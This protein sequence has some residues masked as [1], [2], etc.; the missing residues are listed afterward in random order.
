MHSRQALPALT[1]G[2][3]GVVFGDIGTSPLYAMKE[4]FNGHHP[5][6][7]TPENIFGILSMVFWSIMVMVSIKY[8]AIIMRADNRGEG[9]SLALLA[10]I[11]DR[12]KSSGMTWIITLLG[13]FAAALFYGDSM[14]TPAISVLSAVEGLEIV[15]PTLKPYVIP[16]TLGILTG[17]FLIQK[18]GTG[19]VGML[20]GPVMMLW[21]AMLGIL[22]VMEVAHNP[23]VLVALNPIHAIDFIHTHTGLAFLALGSV[24][25]AVTGGEALYTD[26]GHF[27]PFP[28]RLAWFGFV[29][30]TLVL[31]YFG[32]GALLLSEPQ[33][34]TSPFFH[35]APD[36][37]LIPLVAMATV[38]T[39][40]ASQAVI[41]GAFSVAR[42]AI[43]M[44]FLPRMLIVHTSDQA[45]GQIYVPF[46]NWTLYL[47]VVALVIGFENSSNLA[48]AYG[49]AVTGTMTIDTILIAFVMVLMWRWHWSIVAVVAGS[50]LMFDLAFLSSN[51]LK[52]PAGGWFP[53]AI[54]L[55]SFTVLTTWRRGRRLV[56]EE[57]AKQSIPI[58]AFLE[59]IFDV[60]R[61]RGTAVFM[62]S[63]KEGVPAA[64]LHNLKHNQVLHERVVL[65][66]VQT[67][68]TPYVLDHDRIYLHQMQHGFIRL[69]IQY[70]FME[71]PDIPSALMSCKRF[72]ESFDLMETTFYLSRET[73][74][75]TL[76]RN[77]SCL[78]ARLFALMSRN[79]TSATEFFKIPT[80]RVVE[81][82]TQLE[83]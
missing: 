48:A 37:A 77:L 4:I 21:F 66:T 22:G 71:D 45:Q 58:H 7:V 30:P 46:T 35:M 23:G 43:Q 39:V 11:T 25:L 26:M 32:Q 47:A 18:R 12:A 64:L 49:I 70:G 53:I 50:L 61:V 80:D 34:I 78:R 56:S 82:G 65:V 17:L 20:F 36:W 79:A 51:I 40:I 14:I 8:V 72:G 52:I 63:S 69:I 19:T 13:I 54:G 62:T 55:A 57:M 42:Q 24:V 74:V 6:P 41:S 10:L 68:D 75:P 2:A 60:H 16:V 3:I 81:L 73:I 44:G 38:A 9:G 29:M 27:G 67:T 83:I 1:V 31:N 28:I 33:A 15:T 76:T 5:I 59:S